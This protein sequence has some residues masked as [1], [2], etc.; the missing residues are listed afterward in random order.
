M[1][2]FSL[3]HGHIK[4]VIHL[5]I[6]YIRL[7]KVKRINIGLLDCI[8][9]LFQG[10]FVF[11]FFVLFFLFLF[12]FF[13][14]SEDEHFLFFRIATVNCLLQG[15]FDLNIVFFVFE[16]ARHRNFNNTWIVVQFEEQL[17]EMAVEGT[18][19]WVVLNQLRFDLA[20]A[21]HGGL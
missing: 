12:A 15:H 4:H 1:D 18:S 20:Y 2:S 19:A 17:V 16:I 9:H 13:E 8:N 21:E 10:H 5:F 6:H 11:Y 14:F 7:S 3:T